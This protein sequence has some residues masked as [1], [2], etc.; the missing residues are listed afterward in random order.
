MS[1]TG[2]FCG[3]LMGVKTY[4]VESSVRTIP[5]KKR[6]RRNFDRSLVRV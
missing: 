5:I 3:S 2:D 4:Q 6:G 1:L